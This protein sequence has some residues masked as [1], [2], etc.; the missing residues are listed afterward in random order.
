MKTVYIFFLCLFITPLFAAETTSAE[1]GQDVLSKVT[2]LAPEDGN[3]ITLA[4]WE[5]TADERKEAALRAEKEKPKRMA[6]AGIN[7]FV[8]RREKKAGEECSP[9]CT[10]TIFYTAYA[11]IVIATAGF[12][13][14]GSYPIFPRD[15]DW[16]TVN[17]A[18]LTA[19]EANNLNMNPW[20]IQC[21]PQ[22]SICKLYNKQL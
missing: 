18:P 15:S 9:C 3:A 22:P 1:V 2:S 14:L 20:T 12:T 17:A 8:P 19:C 10:W 13:L 16:C 7:S 21:Y 11:A 4:E 5:R 6:L